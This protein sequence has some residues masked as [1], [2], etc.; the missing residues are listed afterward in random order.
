ML[1]L[2][3][4]IGIVIGIM[5]ALSKSSYL[6]LLNIKNKNMINY[7]NGT[8]SPIAIFWE[9][10][11]SFILPFVIIFLL[12]LNFYLSYLNFII[13][14]YQSSLLFLTSLALVESYSFLGFLKIFLINFPV[15][16]IYFIA[17]FIWVVLCFNRAKISHKYKYFCAGFDYKFFMSLMRCL[18]AVLILSLFIAVVLPLILKTAIFILF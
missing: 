11:S 15:N 14:I 6:G 16:V 17:L 1:F 18:F 9:S 2:C 8:I 12:S 10:F 13:I 4:F 3:F 5:I 7:I